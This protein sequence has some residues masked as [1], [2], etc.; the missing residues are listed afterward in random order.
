MRSRKNGE[1]SIDNQI[2]FTGWNKRKR[3]SG[4]RQFTREGERKKQGWER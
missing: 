4:K 2:I 3:K 1:I